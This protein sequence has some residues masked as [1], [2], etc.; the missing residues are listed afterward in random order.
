MNSETGIPAEE[1]QPQEPPRPVTTEEFEAVNF[2]G[3]LPDG[4]KVEPHDLHSQYGKLA[5]DA[6]GRQDHGAA[7]VFGLLS[8][9]CGIHL[10]PEDRAEPWGPMAVFGNQ[11]SAIPSDFTGEQSATFVAMLDR[12][13]NPGLRARFAD[14]AW[15]NDRK[16][17]GRAAPVAIAAYQEAADGLLTG[18][19][20]PYLD[21][22]RG[23]FEA[24]GNIQRAF[25]IAHATTKKDAK[26]RALFS[27]TLNATALNLYAAAKDEKEYV[28]FL[29]IAE[30]ILRHG[31]KEPA[32]I[33]TDCEE[34]AT[35]PSDGNFV[36]P[37]KSIWEFAARLHRNAD[38]KAAEQRCLFA[39]VHQTLEMRKQVG[40][41]GA[42][43][44]WVNQ[45]LLELRHVEGQEELE[46]KLV[47][48]LRQLQR[49]SIKEM[50]TFSIPLD[51]EELRG[52]AEE[53]FQ[54]FPFAEAMRQFG[55]FA[56]STPVEELKQQA[57]D[58]LRDHPLQAILTT[59]HIDDEGKP[60]ATSP[61]AET[62]GEHSD[63]WY[64]RVA[65]Q[66]EGFRWQRTVAGVIEPARFTIHKRFLIEE[67]HLLPIVMRSPFVPESQAPLIALGFARFFQGDLMSAVHL[68][69]P[70]L[71]P[72]LR[73]ILKMNGRDPV[74]QF[75][76]GTEE[77]FDINAMFSRMRADLNAVFGENLVY[78]IDL[79]FVGRPG[80][81]LRNELSHGKIGAGGCFHPHV[82]YG[83][84][85]IYRLCIA[86]LL[87]HWERLTPELDAS[88]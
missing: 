78:E 74:R 84:W 42:E 33:A 19:F 20:K 27:D 13:K 72:C 38:D 35:V 51:V 40:S 71:E 44:H 8:N 29:H 75:D 1:R 21:R 58:Q 18:K 4:S 17:A 69:I 50:S 39:A 23:S 65:L 83:C 36:L 15:T 30:L 56:K 41:A 88:I 37:I 16:T 64:R 77:D 45:A 47:V 70:Q 63:E 32:T 81:S 5:R 7:R 85:L 43:A 87:P 9:V 60:V 54:N 55:L 82:V 61:G 52:R 86:F 48:E 67:R 22:G 24:L 31:L 73:H 68:L 66:N 76:D 79:L 59:A 49:A 34:V 62:Q 28:V 2:E 12:I 10:K 46:D 6:G 11:R 26:G 57:H 53:A 3:A 25:A 14:I 80:P